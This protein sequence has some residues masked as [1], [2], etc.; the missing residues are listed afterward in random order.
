MYYD[1]AKGGKMNRILNFSAGPSTLPVEV[2]EKAK[3]EMLNYKGC[4]MSVM[5]M[6]HRSATYEE[7]H[8]KTKALFKE[9]LNVEDG[10]EIL[11]LQGG[12]SSQFSMIPLNLL[13]KEEKAD[14]LITGSWAKKAYEE[15]KRFANVRVLATS[16]DRSYT[17][18]PKID[19][20]K[21]DKEAKFLYLCLNNTIY[22]TAVSPEKVEKIEFPLV[23]D[24][25]SNILSQKYDISKFDLVFA[26]AQKNIGISGVTLV[27]VKKELLGRAQEITPTMFNYKTHMDKDSKYNT[28]PC[29]NIYVSGLMAEWIK[30]QGGVEAMEQQNKEK[31]KLLYDFI[32]NSKFYINSVDPDSRSLM[33]VVF[34]TKEGTLDGDFINEAKKKGI[35]N[36]K[37]HRSVGGMRASIYNAMPISGVESLIDFM[38]DFETRNA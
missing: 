9:L 35:E 38:K 15:A 36:I 5:E 31:A 17:Y 10:Y 14:Y 12:G 1:K 3:M 19:R 6:S 24:M 22:G 4:G 34:S 11:F 8:N 23:G 37:G 27:I 26:G 30:K 33:N 13:Q 25:S 18:I 32:D 21:I 20:D 16:E 28:P 29:F 7:I 2:L